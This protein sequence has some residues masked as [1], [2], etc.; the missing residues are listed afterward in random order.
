VSSIA[1]AGPATEPAAR[2]VVVGVSLK[3]YFG[4]EETLRWARRV[5]A[6]VSG[7]RPAEA[8]VDVFVL[9]SFPVL[10]Q[11]VDVFEGTGVGV[12]AQDLHWEDA[13]AF[14]GEVSGQMLA[15]LGCRWA[16]VG[17]AERRRLFGET[18]ALVALKVDAAVRNG[19][20]PIVC[21]GED[22]R[23]DTETAARAC[24]RQLALALSRTGGEDPAAPI[25]VAYEP[26]WAIGADAPASDDHIDAVCE[27]LGRALEAARPG[28][29]NRVIYGGTAGPGLLK[30]LG[31]SVDGLFLGRRVHDPEAIKAVVDEAAGRSRARFAR[32]G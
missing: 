2:R 5:A 17:H 18:D 16:C 32:R 7:T 25:V 20:C 28:G 21:I 24:R 26:V 30:R 6:I 27:E 11:V 13:G 22:E 19:L 3:M 4:Y 15:E 12:G 14:T 31:D 23:S 29:A 9:P 8:G 10:R 1:G